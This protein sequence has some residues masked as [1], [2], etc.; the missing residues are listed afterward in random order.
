M[1]TIILMNI[2][3][4]LLFLFTPLFGG[5]AFIPIWQHGAGVTYYNI[6]INADTVSHTMTIRLFDILNNNTYTESIIISPSDAYIWDTANWHGWYQY[7][8]GADFGFGWGTNSSSGPAGT[9]YCWGAIW[10]TYS[11]KI[12]GLSVLAPESG[13]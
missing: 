11:G 9:M 6:Q 7:A 4:F 8:G 12:V 2:P 3:V 10:G 13:F 5:T 1:K